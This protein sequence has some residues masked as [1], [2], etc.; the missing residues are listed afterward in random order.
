MK[1]A[2]ATAAFLK[3]RCFQLYLS[4]VLIF[5]PFQY[6]NY[7]KQKLWFSDFWEHNSRKWNDTAWARCKYYVV[8][9]A[10]II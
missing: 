4:T 7:E 2:T 10:S 6:T 3:P 1:E 8:N 5:L 9:L